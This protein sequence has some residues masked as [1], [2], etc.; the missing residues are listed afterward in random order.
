MKNFISVLNF[1]DLVQNFLVWT[2]S[3]IG[4]LSLLI[5]VIGGVMCMGSTGDEQKIITA[6]RT[7]IYAIIGLALILGSY[8]VIMIL[9]EVLG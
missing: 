7:I 3:I 5:I 1:S 9:G 8:A 2:L 4:S 6:K